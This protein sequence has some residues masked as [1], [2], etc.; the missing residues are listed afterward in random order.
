[1]SKIDGQDSY[2]HVIFPTYLPS[3]VPGCTSRPHHSVKWVPWRSWRPVNDRWVT[4][5]P[6]KQEHWFL[7]L[8]LSSYSDRHGAHRRGNH[9]MVV[10]GCSE[11]EG[12]QSDRFDPH[13]LLREKGYVESGHLSMGK[14][15][16]L[17]TAPQSRSPMSM[18]WCKLTAFLLWDKFLRNNLTNIKETNLS[19]LCLWFFS[20]HFGSGCA[21]CGGHRRYS[22][23]QSVSL[24]SPGLQVALL[25]QVMGPLGTWPNQFYSVFQEL[26]FSGA[27]LGLGNWSK[28]LI[29][30]AVLLLVTSNT[31]WA[32]LHSGSAA[33]CLQNPFFFFIA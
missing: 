32:P 12:Y 17:C 27:N 5:G 31:H 25:G 16:S 1:M 8:P 2:R 6:S 33:L 7:V 4:W 30:G 28:Y 9:W 19:C 13:T 18:E 22:S 3:S 23:A 29:P 24:L 20:A 26:G 11:E 14:V 10:V 21:A 15:L